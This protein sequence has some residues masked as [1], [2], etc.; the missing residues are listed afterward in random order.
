MRA[1]AIYRALG[2]MAGLLLAA[3]ATPAEPARRA[4][5][6]GI[7]VYQWSGAVHKDPALNFENLTGAAGDPIWLRS[8]LT[9]KYG[10]RDEDVMV[11]TDAAATRDAI[12][13]A[14]QTHLI[15]KSEPGDVA[16]FY[17]AGHGSQRQDAA[18]E[19]ETTLV[20]TDARDPDGKVFDIASSE[21]HALFLAL[22]A[23]TQNVTSIL[24]SCHS[25]TAVRGGPSR[26]IKAD[27]HK[28]VSNRA[29][30]ASL[31]PITPVVRIAASRADEES[32]EYT[33]YLANGSR[34][35][36]GMLSY[37]LFREL[38]KAGP[39]TTWQD[40]MD[41]TRTTVAKQNPTQN[42][43]IQAPNQ[44]LLLFGGAGLAAQ[45]PFVLVTPKRPLVLLNAGSLHGLATGTG[46]DVYPP[47]TREFTAE[48]L[49]KITVTDVAD[50]TSRASI[51]SG[52]A[53]KDI[54]EGSRAVVRSRPPS[55]FR[56][57]V[58]FERGNT[59]VEAV[60]KSALDTI[61]NCEESE[62][63]TADVVVRLKDGRMRTEQPSG[64]ELSPAVAVTD[65]DAVPH[66][67]RQLSQWARWRRLLAAEGGEPTL[68]LNVTDAAGRRASEVTDGATITIA[69]CNTGK[70]PYFT[71]VVDFS[72]DGSISPLDLASDGVPLTPGQCKTGGSFNLG[73]PAGRKSGIEIFKAFATTDKV[74]MDPFV[75][76]AIRGEPPN[77]AKWSS[78]TRAITV[79]AR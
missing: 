36:H 41:R 34:V 57:R 53:A 26:S 70:Q 43:Q 10:F 56:F 48:P 16:L 64:I 40:V 76:T 78:V 49:A 5:L 77:P 62:R 13:S 55:T 42:P 60:R 67:V 45:E 17:F 68:A 23:K 2:V 9:S 22:L 35:Q 33:E 71:R 24:D 75:G 65:D 50:A 31:N 66:V 19:T 18:G 79:S 21:L 51:V 14:F 25:D 8:I 11:L 15:A 69:L 54:R 3:N 29:N 58:Y 39:Q 38:E 44:N 30:I 7:N 12:L 1:V 59:P 47:G 37:A 63:R 32:E 73:V 74:D 61:P 52:A 27:D 20:P 72:S 6:V 28:R 46:L 4:V